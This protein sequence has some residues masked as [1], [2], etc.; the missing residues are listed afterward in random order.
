MVVGFYFYE[1]VDVFFVVF[2]DI[3]VR[4]WEEMIIMVVMNNWCVVFVGR[5]YIFVVYFIGVVNYCE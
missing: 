2:V 1:N 5:K 3:G 4:V